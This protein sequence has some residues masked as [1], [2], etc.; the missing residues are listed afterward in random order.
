M[1]SLVG[2][3]TASGSYTFKK[4]RHRKQGHNLDQENGMDR[5]VKKYLPQ[6]HSTN[7]ICHLL[8][9]TVF[10]HFKKTMANLFTALPCSLWGVIWGGDGAA[11]Y[12]INCNLQ[13]EEVQPIH[14][15][16]TSAKT[17][18]LVWIMSFNIDYCI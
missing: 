5:R 8:L 14:M 13:F 2:P 16:V 18:K 1:A 17:G 9:T 15:F 10:I 4:C 3:G 6:H 11:I 7:L 12:P